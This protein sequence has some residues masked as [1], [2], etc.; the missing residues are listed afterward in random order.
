MSAVL[1]IAISVVVFLAAYGTYGAYL[2][3]KWGID[4]TKKTPA[5]RLNDG[6]D[7]L[8]AKAPVLLGHHF[9]SIAGAGPIVGPIGA[10]I[11]GWL[12]V[13]LWIIIGSIF[14]GG[15]HDMGALFASVRHDG[16]S[17]GEVIGI[18][19][20]D[21]GRKLF[22][23]FSW[24]TLLL[25]VAAFTNIVAGT[26]VTVPEAA[27]SSVLFIIVAVGFGVLVYRKGVSLVLGS[28]VGV[29]LLAICIWLGTMFPL[30]LSKNTWMIIL[31]GYIFV[32]SV[33]PVWILLQPR[34][35][36][37]SF[38]LYAM[39]IGGVIG[40]LIF[41][42]KLQLSAVTSFNVGGK[43]MFPMLFVT[44][45]CGAISGFHS[46]VGSGTTS[47]QLDTESDIK[48]VGFGSMLIE[49]VLAVIA[50]I[51]IAYISTEQAAALANPV[52]IFSTGLGTF[53]GSFGIP[54]EVGTSFTAL[55]I[56]AFALTSLDTATRLARFI[57][58]E[59]F[60]KNSESISENANILT[61][62]YV[63]TGITVAI[64]GALAFYGW[65]VIW[66]IFGSANQ[67]LS[68]IALL[69]LG[70]WLKKSGREH[71]M[72]TL[73]MVFMFAVTIVALV[74]LIFA[75]LT[76]YVLLGFSLA[77]LVLSL[78]LIKQ[79]VKSFKE[80]SLEGSSIKKASNQ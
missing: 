17:L 68:A 41:N 72:A 71:K 38:L 78:V 32:A 64:S 73:P 51:T 31:L 43:W 20:G 74:Q 59:G 22:S 79:A 76:N 2:A 55:A 69:A 3:K 30:V 16:K 37:N 29:A 24:L 46:L 14:F 52:T 26:F 39:L 65:T 49:G 54:V 28:V 15:V 48:L 40:I 57:F 61:N 42:P 6:V 27:T 12:P 66:P 5:H 23:L 56:S 10:A 67:L 9:S 21:S 45:A 19:I 77:L 25:V 75:N 50:L 34:D 7:Y 36:L 60:A 44:V 18:N 13:F 53:M 35:Y 8:P 62:R 70:V 80:A 4:V 63:S 33:T 47:K 11:F 58:Q 1:L